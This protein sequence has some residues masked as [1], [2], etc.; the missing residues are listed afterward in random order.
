MTV[1]TQLETA[2]WLQGSIIKPE[3][4]SS[5]LANT[6]IEYNDKL[7]C[8][9][10]SQ[11]C[12]IAHH[13]VAAD[14]YI[15]ISVARIIETQNG[16]LTYNKN[17]R[18]L[19]TTI[20]CR[21]GDDSEIVYTDLY[22]ELKAYEKIAIPKECLASLFPDNHRILEAKQLESYIAWLAA[23]YSR[24]ALPTEFNDRI[25]AAD[26]KDSRKK[27]AKKANALLSGIYVEVIP[28]REISS[29]ETYRVNLLGLVSPDFNGNIGEVEALLE[30]YATIMRKAKMEVK[31][32]L[33]KED[34][35]SIALIKRFKR[36]Y[37]DDLSFK[38]E[39]PLP[40]EV[41]SIL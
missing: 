5:I 41:G 31:A 12:D 13:N 36:F 23:R 39:T 7:I 9:V 18:L 40:P 16:N 32:I 37:Y 35:V 38:D 28:D 19:H 14:P 27:K 1:G 20:M 30:E 26:P 8:I 29:K 17:P 22:V 25:S 24:P 4:L 3:D 21:S 33:R 2:G 34:E 15:E 10:A 6:E 11:S